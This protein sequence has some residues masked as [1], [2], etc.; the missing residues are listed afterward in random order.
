MTT[1]RWRSIFT[2]LAD[3]PRVSTISATPNSNSY[4]SSR[5]ARSGR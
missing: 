4:R 3:N 5:I 2:E 1:R